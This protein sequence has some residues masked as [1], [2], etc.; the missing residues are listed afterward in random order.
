LRI[1]DRCRQAANLEDG[2]CLIQT[3]NIKYQHPH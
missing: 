2:V 1:V 3:G